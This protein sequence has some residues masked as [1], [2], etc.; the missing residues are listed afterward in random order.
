MD[1]PTGWRRLALS[2]RGILGSSLAL[3]AALLAVGWFDYRTTRRELL[4]L[5]ETHATTLRETVAAATRTNAAASAFAEAQISARVRDNA[6]LLAAVDRV[7]PL[8]AQTVDEIARRNELFRVMVYDREGT[9]E[10]SSIVEGPAAAGHGPGEGPG[11]GGGPGRGPGRGGGAGQGPGGG[12]PGPGTGPGAGAAGLVGRVLQGPEDEV[13]GDVHAGRRAG[14]GRLAA[15]VRRANG[16][17]VLV[18][19]DATAV[20]SLQQQSSLDTLLTETVQHATDVAYIVVD[21]GGVRRSA[22]PLPDDL[23]TPAPAS[24]SRTLSLDSRPILE[25]SGRVGSAGTDATVR[26]GMR[27]DEVRRVERRYLLRQATSLLVALLLGGLGLGLVWLRT[28][29]GSLAEAHAKAREALER[30]DRLAAMGELAST[31]AH[32][33]RNPLNAIAMSAQRLRREAFTADA[34]ADNV[35]LVDVIRRESD[36]INERVQQFLA[37]ARPPRL[38]PV[39]TPVGPWLASIVEALRPSASVKDS[40]I[41]LDAA[42]ATEADIDMEQLRQ[43]VDNLLRNAIEATPAGQRVRVRAS[44]A[45]DGHRIEVRDTGPGIPPDV[46]PRIFDLYFTTK[47]DGTGVGLAHSQQIVSA[48]G[49]RIEVATEVGAGTTFTIVLPPTP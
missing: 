6:R 27:L 37:F 31:V 33:I 28:Q 3:A 2:R 15:V 20:L 14:A 34:D 9:R 36:R 44:S 12:G 16:G 41:D 1:R 32:E 49:G 42:G 23:A 4:G 11:P 30:R 38:D 19:A 40:G 39:R 17:A 25:F 8:D 10:F 7:R 35:A 21:A 26:V 45:R 43:A 13:V 5:V 24:G 18:N 22:G 47:K 46:L 29:Y 48:H